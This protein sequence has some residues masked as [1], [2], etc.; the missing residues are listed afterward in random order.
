[1]LRGAASRV[2]PLAIRP[3]VGVHLKRY[4]WAGI[5]EYFSPPP[6]I[7]T[8]ALISEKKWTRPDK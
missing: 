4:E 3:R 1:M 7:L 6:E 5:A 8:L 2:G